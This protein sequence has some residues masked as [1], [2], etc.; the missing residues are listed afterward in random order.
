MLALSE[1]GEGGSV[2]V[3][4]CEVVGGRG[5][6]GVCELLGVAVSLYALAGPEAMGSTSEEQ[7]LK[8]QGEGGG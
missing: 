7:Q 4:L 3:Q 1:G 2:A 6:L 8:V 5:E